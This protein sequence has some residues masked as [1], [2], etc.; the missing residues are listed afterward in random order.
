MIL[1]ACSVLTC[2]SVRFRHPEQSLIMILAC[3]VSSSGTHVLALHQRF[4]THLRPSEGMEDLACTAA[5]TALR[6]TQV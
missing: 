6:S 5:P 2:I 3:R 1:V 4:C